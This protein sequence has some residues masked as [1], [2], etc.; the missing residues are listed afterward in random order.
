MFFNELSNS[1]HVLELEIL[2]NRK[3]RMREGGEALR[4]LHFTGN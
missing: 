4:V 3:G 2:K 1:G